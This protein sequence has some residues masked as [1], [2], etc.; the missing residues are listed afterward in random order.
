MVTVVGMSQNKNKK[1][2]LMLTILDCLF[3]NFLL[4][5][6]NSYYTVNMKKKVESYK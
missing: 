6:L 2:Q 1:D 5:A 4:V 3:F